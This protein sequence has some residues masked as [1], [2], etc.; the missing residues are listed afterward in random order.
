[1]TDLIGG[2]YTS[3][4]EAQWCL[5]LT[6]MTLNTLRM[7]DGQLSYDII[8][9]D[10]HSSSSKSLIKSLQTA[11]GPPSP[12]L[13]TR[14]RSDESDVSF[15][16]TRRTDPKNGWTLIMM[17]DDSSHGGLCCWRLAHPQALNK[18]SEKTGLNSRAKLLNQR[19][20]CKAH[21]TMQRS[22]GVSVLLLGSRPKQ[23]DFTKHLHELRSCQAAR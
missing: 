6:E 13:P 23:L 1:M 3:I 2:E 12:S 16:Q 18:S 22:L 15:R 14:R 19:N 5:S 4:C 7:D 9:V 11:S 20:K 8:A 10:V 17:P 21:C